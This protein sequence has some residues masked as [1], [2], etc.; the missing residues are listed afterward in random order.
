[1][2]AKAFKYS[3][4]TLYYSVFGVFVALLIGAVTLFFI[5]EKKNIYQKKTD[6]LKNITLFKSKQVSEWYND[7]LNDAYEIA[8]NTSLVYDEMAN[9]TLD[10]QDFN[11]KISVFLQGVKAEHDYGAVFLT[12]S[13]GNVLYSSNEPGTLLSFDTKAVLRQTF[14]GRATTTD[15]FYT[16][17]GN[18][19][20]SFIAAI[21]INTQNHTGPAFMVMRINPELYLYP[22][23]EQIGFNVASTEIVLIRNNND[24][25]QALSALKDLQAETFFGMSH[26]SF[27]GLQS[28]QKEDGSFEGIDYRGKKVLGFVS[29]IESTSWLLLTKI[30]KSDVLKAYY[31]NMMLIIPIIILAIILT[32][33]LLLYINA[34]RLT[35]S[36]MQLF[37]EEAK[38]KATLYSIGDAVIITDKSGYIKNMNQVA[39]DTT[40]WK[41]SEAI[42]KPVDEVFNIINETTREKLESPVIKVMQH[43]LIVNLTSHTLLIRRDGS[44]LP[45]A[46][47]GAPIMDD[48]G[49]ISGVVLVFRDQSEEHHRK[50]IIEQSE[51][52]YRKMFINN[53]QPM[54]IYQTDTFRI[55]EVNDAMVEKYGYSRE[56]FLQMDTTALRPEKEV[57]HYI[58]QMGLDSGELMH[59]GEIWQHRLKNGEII[60]VEISSHLISY[61]KQ[62]AR[63]VL[64]SD[65]S[66]R[67]HAEEA[68]LQSEYKFRMLFENHS[69]K[70]MIVNPETLKIEDANNAACKFYGW[71]REE[72]KNMELSDINLLSR[73][74]MQEIVKGMD[75]MPESTFEFKHKKR[76]G[77]V[78]D[79]EVFSSKIYIDDKLKKRPRKGLTFSSVPSIKV[80]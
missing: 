18:S 10:N 8:G 3:G 29:P 75:N 7:E 20:I 34:R 31:Q 58:H 9:A 41:E 69:A 78:F 5:H 49:K 37:A 72:F 42:G 6:E 74:E 71:T 12:D 53:P 48:N 60:S 56:E 62:P 68:L 36:F 46:D 63:H 43:G 25:I 27:S 57:A 77:S 23:V 66:Q 1:M 40:G 13:S 14:P 67:L 19:F 61:N 50:E 52:S 28:K 80:R 16:P 11:K 33:L 22:W 38:F 47:S 17:T 4:K 45:V 32:G 64:I 59:L 73:E 30:D 51:L 35:S 79:A 15:I 26:Y 70:K 76:D 39:E 44:E 54:L 24:S 21:K 2:V 65:I 55:L